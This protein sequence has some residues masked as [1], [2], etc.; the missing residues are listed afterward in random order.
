MLVVRKVIHTSLR[1]YRSKI[2]P[3]VLVLEVGKWKMVA[4]KVVFSH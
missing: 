1:S 4:S 3:S 2:L